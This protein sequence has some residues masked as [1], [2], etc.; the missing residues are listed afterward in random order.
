MD[1]RT[2]RQPKNIIPSTTIVG[3][4]IMI[5]VNIYLKVTT[6]STASAKPGNIILGSLWGTCIKSCGSNSNCLLWEHSRKYHCFVT[7]PWG[8]EGGV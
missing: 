6:M 8:G 1:A 7:F 5:Q 2:D 3:G 4:G